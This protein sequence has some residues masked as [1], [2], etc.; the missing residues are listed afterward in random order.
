[1]EDEATERG[2][3]LFLQ[4]MHPRESLRN[5]LLLAHEDFYKSEQR[6]KIQFGKK[7]WSFQGDSVGLTEG[8]VNGERLICL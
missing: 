3:I 4:N 8:L 1:M 7:A 2:S 6:V 5:V